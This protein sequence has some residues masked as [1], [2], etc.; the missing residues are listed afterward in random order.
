MKNNPKKIKD[1]KFVGYFAV[2]CPKGLIYPMTLSRMKRF[3]IESFMAW[4]EDEQWEWYLKKGY[5]CEKVD[6]I[7]TKHI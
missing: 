1:E 4:R 3:S 5:S 6:A 2:I 7:I